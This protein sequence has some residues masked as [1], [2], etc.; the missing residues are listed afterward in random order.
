M[1][2]T[3]CDDCGRNGLE[4]EFKYSTAC[5]DGK[6]GQHSCCEKLVCVNGCS[7]TLKCGHTWTSSD[8]DTDTESV[9]VQCDTCDMNDTIHFTWW[10]ITNAEW[11]KRYS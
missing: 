10:G 11:E 5:A 2:T 7:F 1:N 9:F 4:P 8:T 3:K 6:L